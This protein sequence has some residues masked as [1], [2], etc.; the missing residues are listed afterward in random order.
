[1]NLSEQVAKLMAINFGAGVPPRE[2]AEQ[3]IALIE[4]SKRTSHAT[5]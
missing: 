2:T 5:T 1:M 4:Q 3:V